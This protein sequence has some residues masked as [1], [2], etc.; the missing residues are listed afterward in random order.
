MISN[1]NNFLD[2]DAVR[3]MREPARKR[4]KYNNGTDSPRA[5]EP[6]DLPAK[7]LDL[8]REVSSTG[9]SDRCERD[10]P[11]AASKTA[12]DS[13]RFTMFVL[14]TDTRL[15]AIGRPLPR[16]LICPYV[17]QLVAHTKLPLWKWALLTLSTLFG[18]LHRPQPVASKAWC[19]APQMCL[20][21]ALQD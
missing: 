15:F 10:E 11:T 21:L 18:T 17:W 14:D 7:L 1:S 9:D 2:T 20:L 12:R 6:A 13:K 8:T 19:R 3:H 5:Q 4:P 16:S